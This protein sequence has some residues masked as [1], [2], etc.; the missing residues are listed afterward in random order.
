MYRRLLGPER[1]W[2]LLTRGI[3][4]TARCVRPS[5]LTPTSSTLKC[6]NNGESRQLLLNQ[7]YS[8]RFQEANTSIIRCMG[9]GT[10]SHWKTDKEIDEQQKTTMNH[11]P[12][13]Q[14]SW[15]ETYQENQKKYNILLAISS[16]FTAFTLFTMYKVKCFEFN[17]GPVFKNVVIDDIATLGGE[18]RAEV[19]IN[20]DV[21][22][23]TDE[24]ASEPV[25]EE[26]A[27]ETA[28]E[29]V[30]PTEETAED[31]VAEA[32][33][34]DEAA[35][36]DPE[37]PIVPV[38]AAD[39]SE[40]PAAAQVEEPA[41]VPAEEPA[42]TPT[43]EPGTTPAEEPAATPAEEPTAT[44]AEEPAATPVEEPAATSVEEPAATSVEEPAATPVEEPAATPAEEPA[45]IPA[46][47]P[48]ST[49][50]EEPA[51]TPA[52]E[53][54]TEA[55]APSP[56]GDDPPPPPPPAEDTSVPPPQPAEDSSSAAAGE[57]SSTDT[58][59]IAEKD[60]HSVAIDWSKVPDIPTHVPYLLVGAGTASFAAFRYGFA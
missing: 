55:A 27:A 1:S 17:P 34:S 33:S 14:G 5:V 29:T 25:E 23:E 12:V 42:A 13:P 21:V 38:T 7:T 35:P 39:E 43:E 46:E 4:K 22:P 31:P 32:A 40:E 26:I 59:V 45:S 60:V 36:K 15:Q 54:A 8:G 16:T 20:F 6:N 9:H 3:S 28:P 48:A 2:L 52:E 19:G 10:P 49:P 56:P 50:A 57:S 24:E 44:P 18:S 58:S 53:P 11:L 30:A 51:A 41:P 47:E 37:E